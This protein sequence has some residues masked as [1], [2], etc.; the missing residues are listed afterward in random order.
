M[1]YE[2][3]VR[4]KHIKKKKIKNKKKSLVHLDTLSCY[5]YGTWL[6]T[7]HGMYVFTLS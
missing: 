1:K 2:P 6:P 3:L 7:G 4:Q 5:M